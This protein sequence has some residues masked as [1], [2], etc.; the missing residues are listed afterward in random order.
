MTGYTLLDWDTEFFGFKVARITVGIDDPNKLQQ[1]LDQAQQEHVKLVYWSAADNPIN[2]MASEIE[3]L[4]GSLV[5]IKTTYA[6]DLSFVSRTSFALSKDIDIKPYN[7]SMPIEDFYALAIQSGEFSRFAVDK[8][9][10]REKYEA[11]YIKWIDASLQKVIADE[12]LVIIDS[13]K[14]AGMVTLG[15]KN[16][17][18]DIGLLAVDGN[19]RGKKFGQ[20]LVNAAQLWFIDNGYKYAQVVTQAKNEAACGLYRKCGY[21]VDSIEYFFHFWL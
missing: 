1:V 15:E 6:M 4:G 19:Y 17:R 13:G 21:D 11:L 3:A 2:T 9:I 16:K 10:P 7:L 18:G 8:N 14:V 20:A 12:V 5:D